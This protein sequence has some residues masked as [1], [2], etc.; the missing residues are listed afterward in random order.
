MSRQPLIAFEEVSFAYA[1]EPRR[2]G[3]RRPIVALRDIDLQI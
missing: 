1:G 3:D 2:S